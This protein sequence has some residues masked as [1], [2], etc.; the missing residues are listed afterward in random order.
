MVSQHIPVCSDTR[1][2]CIDHSVP[3]PDDEYSVTDR[4]SVFSTVS[5]DYSVSV[6]T[7]M[8]DSEAVFSTI[9]PFYSA[10]IERIDW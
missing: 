9:A 5:P 6:R 1:T 3:S 8:T 4:R 2:P 7:G 10:P